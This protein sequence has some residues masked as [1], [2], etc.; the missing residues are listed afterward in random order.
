VGTHRRWQLYAL[1]L[2]AVIAIPVSCNWMTSPGVEGYSR[3]RNI[4]LIYGTAYRPYVFRAFSPIVVRQLSRV[5]AWGFDAEKAKAGYDNLLES[6]RLFAPDGFRS[7]KKWDRD[8]LAEY[9]ATLLYEYIFLILFAAALRRLLSEVYETKP[10]TAALVPAAAVAF[11]PMMFRYHSYLYDFPQLFF[12]TL[13]L[14]FLA[15]RKMKL[16]YL[17]YVVGLFNKETTFLLAFVFWQYEKGKK[18][19]HIR[20]GHLLAMGCLF[21]LIRGLL[22]AIFR[23]NPGVTFEL[24]L[25][26]HTILFLM[27]QSYEYYQ[28]AAAGLFALAVFYKWKEKPEFLHSAMIIWIPLL[29]LTGLFGYLEEFRDYYDA[30]PATFLLAAHSVCRVLDIPMKSRG[31]ANPGAADPS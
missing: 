27:T 26:D 2:Y 7:L 5:V 1:V 29:I 31:A 11:L 30:Y 15:Q 20:N 10:A 14:L 6:M 22:R 8:H 13:G 24:H 19:A 23:D 28:F 16:F 17:V 21:F 9:T 25:F 18:P 12:I 3:A 4:D